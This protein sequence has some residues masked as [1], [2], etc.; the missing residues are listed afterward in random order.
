MV[1]NENMF[2]EALENIFVGA[3]IEG[4]GGYVNLLSIKQ[5]YYS[6]VIKK[7]K[8]N[9]ENDE[10]VNGS[11]KEDFYNLLYNFFEKYFSESGSVYFAKTA[12]WQKVYEK[13]YT[14]NKDVVLFW[15]TNMLYYVKSDILFQSIYVKTKAKED[16]TEYV[17]YFDVGELEQSQNNEKKEFV[18]SYKNTKTGIIEGIH[19]DSNGDKTFVLS[20]E[21]KKGN[22]KTNF[23]ELIKKTGLNLSVIEDAI[24]IFKKQSTVDFFINKNAKEFLEEQLNVFLHQLLL[25]EE[26][27]FEQTRLDQLK[28]V[29]E[30]ALD[31]I[32][33]I[34][35]F[36]NE[37]VGIWE[38]PKFVINSDYIA[39]FKTLKELLTNESFDSFLEK[40][41]NTIKNNNDCKNDIEEIIRETYKR[42][43]QNLY[44]SSFKYSYKNKRI[45][46]SYYKLFSE[47]AKAEKYAE[48]NN[49]D[50]FDG[51][52]VD[53]GE[54]LDGYLVEYNNTKE[55]ETSLLF[56]ELFVDTKY[57]TFDEKID[58][59]SQID[60][61]DNETSGYI[62]KSDNYQFLQCGNKFKNS[63]SL[64]YIDP[65]FNTM[66]EGFAYMDG[67]KDTTWLTQMSDRFSSLYND[68][69][70]KDSSFYVHGDYHCDHFMRVLMDDIAGED[71]F[72]REIIWNTSPA[73]SGFK[74]N[75]NAK[76]YVRQHDTILYY[77]KGSP[78]FNNTFRP[79][80]NE[81]EDEVRNKIG[82]LDLFEDEDKIPYIYRYNENG[83]Y[84]KEEY[85]EIET[86]LNGDVWNDVFSLMYSQNMTRENWGKSNTQ[87]PENLLRRIIQASTKPG[88]T[89]MDV[90]VGSGTTIAAAHKLGR[91]WIGVDSGEFLTDIVI[92]RMKSVVMG[93][94]MPKLSEDLN[95]NGG[96]LVKYYE[97]EQYEDT[98][99]KAIYS[100]SDVCYSKDMFSQYVFFADKK[101]SD[102]LNV[103]DKE[104]VIDLDG[105]YENIDIPETISLLYG[106]KIEHIDD[107]VVKLNNISKPIKYNVKK[108]NN[109]EKVEFIKMLKPLIW[110]GE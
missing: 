31:I 44:V 26:S 86:M 83:E 25:E 46:F 4:E 56:E 51:T 3:P 38:K 78:V 30:Y 11:F 67:L 81:D 99:K 58:L 80:K 103:G 6:K 35:Q 43:L 104:Y 9:V 84:V 70:K 5:K 88:D 52:I 50:I 96:G 23:K 76:N 106:K 102:V 33:F 14:D 10:I 101:L 107:E 1:S 68:Y 60:D 72:K 110:W 95:W 18:F 21:Y 69:L 20:V 57:L 42:P 48:D 7:F 87:K 105:L 109:E 73:I 64:V 8:D 53:K 66:T 55:Y 74:V 19:N 32:S 98:L 28:R 94:V 82:W 100:E 92:K 93:D 91:K 41:T 45:S 40:Y 13:V 27:V 89:V 62:V 61:L 79:Y 16:D 59:L 90:F 54:E 34:S 108:M 97:L 29:K 47:K 65:P 39:S 77:V 49:K 85:P 71:S 17:F 22:R 24:S 63:V 12:N 37:L 36:E 75:P 15:K 2:Y